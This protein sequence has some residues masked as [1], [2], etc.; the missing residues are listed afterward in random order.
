MKLLEKYKIDLIV[1]SR[2]GYR[3]SILSLLE[4]NARARLLDL[5]SGEGKLTQLMADHIGTT[6]VTGTDLQSKVVDTGFV[7]VDLN[8]EFPWPSESFD[9]V[10]AS[11][12]IE[13][14]PNTD[15]F[16]KEIR[17]VLTPNGY[18]VIATPNLAS[19]HNV[20]YLALGKQ[21][22][23]T[24]VSDEMYSWIDVPGHRRVFTA[25]E[26][27]KF[28]T[29]HG[30]R[31]EKLIGSTYYPLPAFAA[32]LACQIDWRHA[33]MLTVKVRKDVTYLV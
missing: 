17:R 15:R 20:A 33:S 2:E 7:S 24:A 16:A 12:I 23:T 22:E 14:L 5:G 8:E 18:A 4:A 31:I 9:V 25:T 28:L 11:H 32:K 21:P 30:F 19:W 1:S 3:Q 10:V 29:Y 26:L 27:Q 6:T 13:H